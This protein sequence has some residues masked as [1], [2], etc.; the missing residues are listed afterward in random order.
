[1]LALLI[2]KSWCVTAFFY[3]QRLLYIE[4]EGSQSAKGYLCGIQD[5]Q[6]GVIQEVWIWSPEAHHK[7]EET[8]L[9][10][11]GFTAGQLWQ[12]LH[13]IT[14]YKAKL[15]SISGNNTS[16]PDEL[17]DIYAWS[18]RT[19]TYLHGSWWPC[20]LSIWGHCQSIFQ[21]G[22]IH[23]ELPAEMAFLAEHWRPRLTN[24]L[25]YSRTSSTPCSC[26]L[27]FP[28]L[29]KWHVLHHCQ[30]EH[31]DLLQLMLLC[32]TNILT[33]VSAPPFAFGF[34]TS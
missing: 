9:D 4:P 21:E 27:S 18:R 32:I 31:G 33:W 20:D 34:L 16:L 23:A 14:S 19:M 26:I 8:I 11:I 1:M 2:I 17:N 29:W 6:T 12:G 3:T 30:E 24:W 13:A 25:E 5:R 22:K 10:K 7:Q 28:S 15:G